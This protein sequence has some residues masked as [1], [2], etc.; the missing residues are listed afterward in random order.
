MSKTPARISVIVPTQRRPES[1]TRAVKS[2][3]RQKSPPAAAD[4]E[5]IVVDNDPAGSAEATVGRLQYETPFRLV[6]VHEP[7]PGVAGARNAGLAAASGEMIAF[8]DD[9][10]EAS[11]GWLSALIAVQAEFDADVVFGP[12]RGRAPSEVQRHRSYFEG[13]FSREGPSEA[14]LLE[15]HYGCGDSLIRRAALPHPT[16]PFARS[17]DQIGGEDDLLFEQ[18]QARGARFAWAPEAWVWEHPEPARFTLG[19]ALRRAFAY[20][21]GPSY[22]CMTRTPPDRAGAA[23]W[24]VVGMGQTVVFGLAALLKWLVRAPDRA[25]TFDRAARGLGKVLWFRPFRQRFY[26]LP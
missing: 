1:L 14:R 23:R 12:V 22:A 8:L 20:G 16:A 2:V 17:R 7:Q 10:E 11:P 18:M 24:M 3:F 5:L 4:L 26:G 13:F 21:Q 9:D 15:G 19:Y 6:Y 25:H